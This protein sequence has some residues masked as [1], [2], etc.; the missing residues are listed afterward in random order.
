MYEYDPRCKDTTPKLTST[1][2]AW[3]HGYQVVPELEQR[4]TN[5]KGYELSCIRHYLNNVD[6]QCQFRNR[7]VKMFLINHF[8]S[9]I[10]F[11]IPN[12]KND[13]I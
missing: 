13:G 7:D 2:H 3:Y 12:K 6:Y 8:V 4:L 10:S 5:E 9:N 1:Q 11:T